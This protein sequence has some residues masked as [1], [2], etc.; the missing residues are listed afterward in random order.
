ML[1]DIATGNTNLAD[2]LLLVAFIVFAVDA[3]LT[4]IAQK[5]AKLNLIAVGLALVA[6]ALL[7][8]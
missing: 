7:Q 1:A 4:W 5:P 8:W 2:W 6:F 3:V